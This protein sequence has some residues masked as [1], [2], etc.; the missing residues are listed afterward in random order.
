MRIEYTHNIDLTTWLARWQ[1][2]N[3]KALYDSASLVNKD[4]I[5]ESRKP[6]TG[7]VYERRLPSGRVVRHQAANKAAGET[8]ARMTGAQNKARGYSID[9][10][11][12]YMGVD[13]SIKYAP[14]NEEEFGDMR[15]GL[16]RNQ[17][18]VHDIFMSR[19]A[20]FLDE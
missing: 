7:R 6:K 4:I 9:K 8:T 1:A 12:A 16:V 19:I 11:T 18:Y 2:N 20:K 10:Q 17:N 5:A 15:K 3:Q 14:K 13:R